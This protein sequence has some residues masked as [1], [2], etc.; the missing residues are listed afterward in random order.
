MEV[1]YDTLVKNNYSLFINKYK[2][3]LDN[4]I[5]GIQYKKLGDICT[6]LPKSKRPAS[7]GKDIGDIDFFT[8]SMKIKKCNVIDYK[9]LSLII[10][11]GEMLILKLVKISVVL[12]IIFY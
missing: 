3:S 4:R 12:Q 5:D 2:V 8:S 10:G 6:F 1:D 7:F 11:T 9:Q